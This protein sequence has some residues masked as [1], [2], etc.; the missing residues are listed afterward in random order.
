MTWAVQTCTVS[1]RS[2]FLIESL[3]IS[4]GQLS[5][6]ATMLCSSRLRSLLP[7]V[8]ETW[9]ECP[10]CPKMQHYLPHRLHGHELLFHGRRGVCMPYILSSMSTETKWRTHDLSSSAA[11]A[12]MNWRTCDLSMCSDEGVYVYDNLTAMPS[13]ASSSSLPMLCDIPAYSGWCGVL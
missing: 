6:G 13:P 4:F 9:G 8:S 2:L 12:M 5:S 7:S 11:D 10:I 1:W 3:G